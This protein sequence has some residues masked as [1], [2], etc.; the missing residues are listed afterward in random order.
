[1]KQIA[2]I[3]PV[4]ILIVSLSTPCLRAQP[5]PYRDYFA[6]RGGLEH[7]YA[8]IDR[9]KRATVAFL[10]G[11]ITF[12]PGWRDK[13]SAYLRAQYPR[14]DFHFIAAGIPSLGSVPHAFRVQRDVLDSGRIDLLFLETAVND[15]GNGTDSLSQVRALEGIVRHARRSNPS[16]DIIMM[17]FADPDKTKD[18]DAGRIPIEIANQ[19]L[20]AVHYGLPSINIAKEVHDKMRHGEFSWEKDF[21][22]IHPAEFGQE[23]YFDNIKALLGNCF[24][25]YASGKGEGLSGAHP[26]PPSGRLSGIHPLPPPLDKASLENGQYDGVENARYDNK[27]TLDKDWTPSDKADTRHGFVHVPVLE[28]SAPGA[29]LTLSFTGTAVGIAVVSGPDAGIISY[30]IDNG[31]FR[32]MDLYTQW[33]SGLHLPWYLLLG[34]G[35]MDAPHVLHIRVS[36]EK[37]PRS[38]G[39]ACRIVHFLVNKGT[40]DAASAT[41][42][43]VMARFM[44]QRFG[45]FIHFGPVTLR[46]TEI[47]WSRNKEV[48]QAD[49]DSLYREFNPALFNADTWV[50]TARA[51]GMKYLTITAKHHDGFCEWPTAYSDY[52]IMHSPFKRDIVGELARACR[53]QGI[54]FCVYFTVLDW[55]DPDYPIHNP[56]DNTQ[57]VT[58]DMAR[59]KERMKN[60][61]GE[62]ITRYHPYMLWFDGYW[63]KPWTAADGREIY[64]YIKSRDAKVIVNNRLGKDPSTLSGEE[65]V[66]DY[67]TPEQQIGKLNMT[68]PWESCITICNQWAWK[69][70]DKMKSLG[71]CIRTLVKTAGGNG[72]LLFNVGP[73]MDGRMEARQVER[74]KEMGAW[75]KKYGES[76][77]GTKGGPYPPNDVYATTRKGNKIYL[78]VFAP[79][80][81]VLT[82]PSLPGV[83]IERAYWMQ[84]PARGSAANAAAAQGPATT[85]AAGHGA[86]PPFTQDDKT[87]YSITLP[88]ILPDA[89]SSVIVLELNKNAEDIPVMQK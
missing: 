21:K 38:Q 70:D 14:T 16:M 24:D 60:E 37:N 40:G 55:H 22:D 43:D 5:L 32:D 50:A 52:N 15:R 3:I 33:S 25:R 39:N 13:V 89:N 42:S 75:L 72:N 1:M 30:G 48:A 85:G 26:K 61:L 6:V 88:D 57:N 41:P 4:L 17:A 68:E 18:Y 86:P 74:L 46:G 84:G 9:D 34:N 78:H 49:Y 56:H 2:R 63:E 27:W 23:L 7:S 44:D 20:V 12:N 66:G 54:L 77:Y 11:S 82:L 51:A 76:I 19:E 53:R 8:A 79:K 73:M 67:L 35:L 29:E 31:P 10:G 47:G 59:F 81:D 28:A 87:G 62:I 65:A 36:G 83:R 64:R 58:G 45:M 69:P 71:E 80:G